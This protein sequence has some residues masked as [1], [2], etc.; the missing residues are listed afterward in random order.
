MRNT[1][2]QHSNKDCPTFLRQVGVPWPVLHESFS[3]EAVRGARRGGLSLPQ[4]PGAQKPGPP[5]GDPQ[6]RGRKRGALAGAGGRRSPRGRERLLG[7][8]TARPARGEAPVGPRSP[9]AGAHSAGERPA[10]GP[11]LG[12][13]EFHFPREE[14]CPGLS[15]PRPPLLR[16]ACAP[17]PPDRIG[18]GGDGPGGAPCP[19]PGPRSRGRPGLRPAV[20]APTS[21]PTSPPLRR[22][23]GRGP[24]PSPREP[25]TPP[26]G[27][28]S[29]SGR[30]AQGGPAHPAGPRPGAPGGLASARASL[31]PYPP[32]LLPP[33]L[34]WLRPSSSR[35]A[36]PR[37]PRAGRPPGAERTAAC[38][39][40]ASAGVKS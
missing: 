34:T 24:A 38:G 1:R 19:R 3:A 18:A 21:A 6:P 39:S 13:L 27:G 28:G 16:E 29:G 20:P 36:G 25:G 22:G 26:G 23:R 5:Q 17:A 10:P 30:E 33:V 32:S 40:H 4:R 37:E 14:G 35:G 11:D 8:G 31:A 15:P 12:R 7:A 2:F 9:L